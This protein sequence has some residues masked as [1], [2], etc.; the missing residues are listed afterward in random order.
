[1]NYNLDDLGMLL[2]DFDSDEFKDMDLCQVFRHIFLK[3]V[4]DRI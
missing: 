3:D 2:E 1:M 4:I